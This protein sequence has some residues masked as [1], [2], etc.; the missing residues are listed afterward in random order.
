MRSTSASTSRTAATVLSVATALST[1]NGPACRRQSN[2]E[3]AP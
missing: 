3:R 1:E 2:P